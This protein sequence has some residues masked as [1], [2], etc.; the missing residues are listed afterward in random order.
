[1]IDRD[2]CD[3]PYGSRYMNQWEQVGLRIKERCL[4]KII[5]LPSLGRLATSKPTYGL[6]LYPIYR[7]S[8]ITISPS[9]SRPILRTSLP[10]AGQKL[11]KSE[12]V[13]RGVGTEDGVRPE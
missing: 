6:L 10:E 3:V 12:L 13:A 7:K 5:F 1:V 8:R 9:S 2:I 11:K 4:M